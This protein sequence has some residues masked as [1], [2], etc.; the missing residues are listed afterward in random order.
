MFICLFNPASPSAA[1][2]SIGCCLLLWFADSVS[3]SVRESS[4]GRRRSLKREMFKRLTEQTSNTHT[5]NVFLFLLVRS[6]T[7]CG[8]HFLIKNVACLSLKRRLASF[9]RIIHSLTQSTCLSRFEFCR[10]KV[11]RFLITTL[12]G[13]KCEQRDKSAI[14]VRVGWI[15][16]CWV[17]FAR[18]NQ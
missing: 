7:L 16:V 4:V 17:L 8:F 11:N 2:A 9:A 1:A 6:L 13:H 18:E 10:Q 12:F 15:K 5:H 3:Q 14:C